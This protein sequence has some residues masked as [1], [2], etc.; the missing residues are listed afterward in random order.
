M[1]IFSNSS[2]GTLDTWCIMTHNLIL[3]LYLCT[4]PFGSVKELGWY[5]VEVFVNR[6]GRPTWSQNGV[7]ASSVILVVQL[8][9][10]F[11]HVVT[12]LSLLL[13]L[14]DMRILSAS[15]FSPS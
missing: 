14:L 10:R 7:V 5:L 6:L 12:D 4:H 3:Y 13:L 1:A 2:C 15:F 11:S 9:W 8:S